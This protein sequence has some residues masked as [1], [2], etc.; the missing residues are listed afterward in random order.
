MNKVPRLWRIFITDLKIKCS[1]GIHPEELSH[2]QEVVIN[3]SCEYES[4]TPNH[5]DKLEEV[6]RYDQI[7]QMIKDITLNRHIFFVEELAEN[8]ADGCLKDPR[9]IKV[10]VKVEKPHIL[11]EAKSVGVEIERTRRG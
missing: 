3:V 10:Q 11:K 1:I 8:I 5:M 7:A 9:I 2:L 4:L 6:V